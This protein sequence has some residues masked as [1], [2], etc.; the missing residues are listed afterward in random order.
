[1]VYKFFKARNFYTHCFTFRAFVAHSKNVLVDPNLEYEERSI[2]EEYQ[3]K[4]KVDSDVIP[5]PM[6][7]KTRWVGE[8]NGISKSPSIFYND[9]ANYLKIIGPD[10]INRLD[11]EYKLGKAYR[12]F[13]DNFVREIYYH[14]I[15]EK[16]EYCILKCRVFLSRKVS[17][18]PYHVWAAV[19]KDVDNDFPG[20]TIKAVYCTCTASLGVSCNHITA[21]LFRVESFVVTGKTKPSK[22]SQLCNWNVPSGTKLILHHCQLRK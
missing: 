14:N 16:S 15:S 18:K 12:D 19:V 2:L 11:R 10:F 3:S 13:A 4:L 1:M 9:V 20:G 8:E 5:D 22:T 17:S 21:F 6:A 7:L